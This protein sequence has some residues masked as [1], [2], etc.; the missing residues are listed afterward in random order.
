MANETYEIRCA[1]ETTNWTVTAKTAEQAK[2]VARKQ[3]KE[4]N[5]D[6]L[7]IWKVTGVK[8][9]ADYSEVKVWEM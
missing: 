2:S 8:G 4:A 6:S 7:S 1:T 5:L 3:N 9:Q